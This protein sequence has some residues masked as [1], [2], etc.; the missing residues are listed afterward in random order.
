MSDS[1]SGLLYIFE[2]PIDAMSHA[3]LENALTGDKN[4]WRRDNR[5]S[6]A[7]TSDAAL[8][9]YLETHPHIMELVLCLDND[10]PGREASVV[11]ARKYAEKG[12]RT[13]IELPR[14]KDYNEDLQL[15][16]A[17]RKRGLISTK[18]NELSL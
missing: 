3:S 4:A 14:S 11:I 12:Y 6:L 10:P 18:R 15:F 8:P 2:S 7:G 9:K 13:R 17:T 5:L 1:Q 16:T